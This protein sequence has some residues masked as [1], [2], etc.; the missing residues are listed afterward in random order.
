MSGH[1]G[2]MHDLEAVVPLPDGK[3]IPVKLNIPQLSEKQKNPLLDTGNLAALI[4]SYTKALTKSTGMSTQTNILQESQTDLSFIGVIADRME[5]LITSM[6]T[7]TSL[8]SELL[9]YVKR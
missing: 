4:E 3:T 5:T 2:M 9:Y 8:Q 7:N 1:L 6:K